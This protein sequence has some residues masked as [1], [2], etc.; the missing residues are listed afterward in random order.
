MA[1]ANLIRISRYCIPIQ[2]N[3]RSSRWLAKA[4]GIGFLAIIVAVPCTYAIGGGALEFGSDTEESNFFVT[5]VESKESKS[6]PVKP[7]VLSMDVD[8][9][10]SETLGHSVSAADLKQALGG[11]GRRDPLHIKFVLENEEK[12]SVATLC[13]TLSLLNSSS[14]PEREIYV[15]LSLRGFS[16]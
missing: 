10:L 4:G 2:L 16:R 13:K 5:F 3:N 9:S 1:M 8:G 6:D 12:T 7:L 15:V 11:R 14:N